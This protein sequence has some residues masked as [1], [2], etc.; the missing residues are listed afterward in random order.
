MV[1]AGKDNAEISGTAQQVSVDRNVTVTATAAVGQV[2]TTTFSLWT[3]L[4]T[5]FSYASEEG[6]YIGVGRVRRLTPPYR[7]FSAACV[8]NAARFTFR[9]DANLPWFAEFQAPK[10]V[11]LRVGTYEGATRPPALRD[12]DP[13][14]DISGEFRG[15]NHLTGRFTIREADFSPSGQVRQFWATFEQHCESRTP[16]LY[17][18]VRVTN[19]PPVNGNC[20][21]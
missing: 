12:T 3:I 2:A 21:R 17:G 19:G 11:P 13:G 14:L 18:D 6:D 8:D 1:P 16:A 7:E 20:L 4:P 9:D 5:F 10:G 15:C